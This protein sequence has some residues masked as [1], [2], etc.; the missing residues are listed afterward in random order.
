MKK[1]D[2]GYTFD[3]HAGATY[4]FEHMPLAAAE[5]HAQAAETP[6]I[7]EAVNWTESTD[8]EVHYNR[9]FAHN[10]DEALGLAVRL[11]IG[12]E[13]GVEEVISIRPATKSEAAGGSKASVHFL[14]LMPGAISSIDN[15][16]AKKKGGKK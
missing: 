12:F 2:T 13:E 14:E 5:A 10:F 8:G 16:E 7:V 9:Y 6:H 3:P 15:K 4:S 1:L 11:R